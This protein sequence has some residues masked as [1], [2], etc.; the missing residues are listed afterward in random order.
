[1]RRTK[2][3]TNQVR[4]KSKDG[5]LLKETTQTTQHAWFRHV[6]RVEDERY[7]K[8]EWRESQDMRIKGQR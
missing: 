5:G 7:H 2:K 4:R 8:K 3:N 6:N 1:L